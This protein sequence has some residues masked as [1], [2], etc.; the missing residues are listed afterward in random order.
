M[1][2]TPRPQPRPTPQQNP[3]FRQRIADHLAGIDQDIESILVQAKETEDIHQK[4]DLFKEL[5]E[6][7]KSGTSTSK[8]SCGN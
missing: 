8:T 5:D 6:L 2:K 7:K 1:G 4:E 3:Q